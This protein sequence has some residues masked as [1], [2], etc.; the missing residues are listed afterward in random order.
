MVRDRWLS[1]LET[2]REPVVLVVTVRVDWWARRSR[3]LGAGWP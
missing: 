3:V 1:G 2:A